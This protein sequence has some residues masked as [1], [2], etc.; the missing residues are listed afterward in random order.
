MPL[1]T[2][3]PVEA[4]A[5]FVQAIN[6]HVPSEIARLMAKDHTF[7]DSQGRAHS[8]RDC[9]I[10]G[11]TEYFQKFPDFEIRVEQML[12][13][14][15]VVAVFGQACGTYNGK[16]GIVPENRVEMTAAWRAVVKSGKIQHWQVYT[17]WTVG[18]KVIE[19][20]EMAG[21]LVKE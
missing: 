19:A 20:D 12:E 3:A 6:R 21:W 2:L 10:K 11:W 13:R 9:L 18:S 7:V 8:G 4:A 5:A 1:P 16:R 17:D 15:G 14:D